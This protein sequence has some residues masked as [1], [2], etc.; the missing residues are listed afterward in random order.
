MKKISTFIVLAALTLTGFS[1][2][3]KM[4]FIEEGTQAS[5]GPCASQNPDFDALL[6][7]NTDK[8]IVLKYQTSWPG[9]DQMN[10][11]NPGDVS[12]RVSYYGIN[13]VP[14]AMINGVYISDDCNAYEG[15]PACLDQ[16]EIDDANVTPADFDITFT[17]EIVNGELIV[18][19]TVLA[20][21]TVTGDLMLRIAIAEQTIDY[22]DVPGGTNG[23]TTFHH[24]LKKFI[25][26]ADGIALANS[27]VMGDTYTIDETFNLGAITVYNYSELEVI[28]FIQNDDDKNVFQAAVVTDLQATVDYANNGTAV[29]VSGLPNSICSGSNMISPIFKLQNNGNDNLVSADIVYSVNGGTE[30]TYSWT[31]DLSTLAN[32]NIDLDPISFDAPDDDASVLTI[33]VTN[34][35]GMTDEDL[36]DNS[37]DQELVLSNETI[38]TVQVHILTDG[39]GDE[40]YWEIRDGN[41]DVYAQ[42]GNPN[43]GIDNVAT[44]VF[45]P[46]ASSESYG[47]DEEVIVDVEISADDCF[48][49]HI[50]DYYGDGLL[51]DGYYEVLDN[52][53]DVIIAENDLVGEE[54]NTFAGKFSNGVDELNS[55]HL[56]KIYPNPA[57][58]ELNVQFNIDRVSDVTIDVTNVLGE[59]V[60]SFDLGNKANGNYTQK[61]NTTDYADGVYLVSISADGNLLTKRIT[62]TK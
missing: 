23:E 62:V 26:S 51:G 46:P 7:A 30:Q 33:T 61:I 53:G 43:V 20:N 59:V 60:E 24:V 22:A 6:D 19:G 15:A 44:G 27:W 35:N 47:N 5:C 9:F 13:G 31:G 29:D 11:D 49:F 57:T 3:A 1:Q 41:G 28:A 32:E 21:A 52:N 42:G 18:A 4:V 14:T 58:T 36:E 34:V 39:Y 2:S 8:A 37:L 50:T 17:A 16:A 25:P 10:L 38:N 12:N 55:I 54:I 40:V 48:V 45:P 56:V